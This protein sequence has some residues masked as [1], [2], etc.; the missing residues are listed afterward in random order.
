MRHTP[1]TFVSIPP[2]NN[3]CQ[4][5]KGVFGLILE[6]LHHSRRLQAERTLRQYRDLMDRAEHSIAAELKL[7]SEGNQHVE[8]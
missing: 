7:R 4:N 6:A 5:K 3:S 8:K 1:S 2:V